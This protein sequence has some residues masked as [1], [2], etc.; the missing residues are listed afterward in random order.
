MKVENIQF[1]NSIKVGRS[2]YSYINSTQHRIDTEIDLEKKIVRFQ[3]QHDGAVAWCP[4]SNVRCWNTPTPVL[5]PEVVETP[6]RRK[7]AGE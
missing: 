2:E 7:P 4:M 5:T 1:L 6:K 3:S